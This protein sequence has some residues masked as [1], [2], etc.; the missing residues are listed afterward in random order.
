MRCAGPP[1]NVYFTEGNSVQKLNIQTNIVSVVAGQPSY[2]ANSVTTPTGI[3]GITPTP[4]LTA[5]GTVIT[6]GP[7]GNDGDGTLAINALLNGPVGLAVDNSGN[8]YIADRSNNEIRE[9]NAV[10]G[11]ITT[12][13][14]TPSTTGDSGTVPNVTTGAISTQQAFGY[15]LN[16]PQGVAVDNSGNIYIANTGSGHID[17]IDTNG[18]LILIAGNT[19]SGN[20]VLVQTGTANG[21]PSQPGQQILSPQAIT[22]DNQGNVYFSDRVGIVR[23]LTPVNAH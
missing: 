1:G 22:V 11:I 6:S 21:S 13:A 9:V 12:L 14:G 23:K 20:P 3:N 18:N 15:I 8:V 7:A 2:L 10:S 5:S 16:A 19:V 17:K 4:Y